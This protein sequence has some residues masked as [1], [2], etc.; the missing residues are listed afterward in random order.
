MLN[1]DDAACVVSNRFG[2]VNSSVPF[3]IYNV[4]CSG[5]EKTLDECISTGWGDTNCAQ[6]FG[7]QVVE[8]VCANCEY[9]ISID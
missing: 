5:M 8:L 7:Y 2:P 6:Y 9:I 3:W 1:Y 4:T